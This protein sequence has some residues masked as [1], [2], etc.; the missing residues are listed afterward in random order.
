MRAITAAFIAA[1]LVLCLHYLLVRTGVIR[2]RYRHRAEKY[3]AHVK[4][5]VWLGAVALAI[6]AACYANLSA[7]PAEAPAALWA[8]LVFPSLFFVYM[9]FYFGMDRSVQERMMIELDNS[10]EHRLDFQ[11]IKQVYNP[12][13]KFKNEIDG[14]VDEGFLYLEG[15]VYRMTLK[16]KLYAKLARWA[17]REL[18]MGKGG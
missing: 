16:G 10:P 12:A 5:L 4:L 7:L 6:F 1:S 17:K 13:I 8:A 2:I 14:M 11:G 9:T 15:N 18:K 3:S